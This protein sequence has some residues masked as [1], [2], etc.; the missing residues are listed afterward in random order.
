MKI[1]KIN[2]LGMDCRPRKLDFIKYSNKSYTSNPS[3]N[4]EDCFFKANE[5]ENSLVSLNFLA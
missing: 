5:R 4:V 1:E 2:G 3:M